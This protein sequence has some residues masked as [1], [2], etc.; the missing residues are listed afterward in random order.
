MQM[1]TQ[2]KDII[3][4]YSASCVSSQHGSYERIADVR[5]AS[6]VD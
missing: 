2:V 4:L 5:G 3:V 6:V 1:H